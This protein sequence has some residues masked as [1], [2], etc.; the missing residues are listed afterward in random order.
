MRRHRSFTAAL[1]L[2][3]LA[4]SS[5]AGQ[6]VGTLVDEGTFLV[7]KTGSPAG[8]ESFK[9]VR[10]DDGNLM[11]TGRYSAGTSH[12]TS[13]LHTDSV[14][15]PIK[16]QL[17]VSDGRTSVLRVAALASG[18]R[19][20]ARS[21]DQRGDESMREYPVPSGRCLILDD[22][23]VHQLYFVA[24]GKRSGA[25]QVINTRASH[26]GTLTLTARGLEPVDV[27]G[28]S[29]TATHYSLSGGGAQ[30]EFWIDAAG[31][32]LRVEIPALG[33]K[34]TREELPR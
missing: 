24:L 20:S 29:V 2:M 11:A 6:G 7:G 21:T 14:G 32:L 31:R 5:V 30:R 8:T 12:V 9:I 34:A 33:L 23:L 18:T 27:A 26:G 19:L 15:T 16:Y 17:N 4:S 1:S 10:L 25:V 13:S 22:D 28:R 3:V